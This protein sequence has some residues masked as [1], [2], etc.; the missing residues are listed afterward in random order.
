VQYHNAYLPGSCFALRRG[1]WKYTVYEDDGK[2]NPLLFNI[3]DDPDEMHDLAGEDPGKAAELDAALNRHMDVGA[4]VAENR[5][6]DRRMFT[7]WR[8]SLPR[9]EYKRLLREEI[10]GCWGQEFTDD[11]LAKLEA[12]MGL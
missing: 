4:V 11:H 1:P 2:L 8:A 9:D 7:T 5:A 6:W 12:W 10:Y 3:A